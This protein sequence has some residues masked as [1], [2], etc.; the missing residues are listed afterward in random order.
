[1]ER[2][3]EISVAVSLLLAGIHWENNEHER[4]LIFSGMSFVLTGSLQVMTRDEAK[5]RLISLGA[6]VTG[7]V[8]KKT[9][10]VV[11]GENAGSK[12]EKAIELGITTLNEK[13]FIKMIEKEK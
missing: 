11:Y 7:S 13:S 5:Q 9:N 8:S 1:M 10:Y 4:N 2:F 6:K 3:L 12:Y